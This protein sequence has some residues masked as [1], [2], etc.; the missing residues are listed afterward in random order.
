[1]R[2]MRGLG[3]WILMALLARG[4]AAVASDLRRAEVS[5][6]QARYEDA[7]VWLTDLEDDAPSMDPQS[8]ARYY[9]MRGMTD[10]RLGHRLEALHYLALAR[11]VAGE[12]GSGLRP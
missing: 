5:Y 1:M 6:E 10:Y 3:L 12:N 8:R 7:L 9:Y 2:A 4:C 11:E